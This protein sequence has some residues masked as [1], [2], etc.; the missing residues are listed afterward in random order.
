MQKKKKQQTQQNQ[1]TRQLLGI[2]GITEYSLK[3]ASNEAVFFSIKPS[4]ISVMSEASLSAKIYSLMSV[5][6]GLTEIDILCVNSRESF[7][8]NKNH[9]KT[10]SQKEENIAV[11]KLLEQDM[12]HLDQI[13]ALTATA[14]EFLLIVRIR[15]MKDKEIFAHLNR[16]E[17]TLNENGFSARRYDGE[18]IKTLLA[19]YFE[20]NSVTEKFESYDGERYLNG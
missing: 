2:E 15:R 8:G 7:E 9:L 4:N 18:D 1:S 13:Q 10:L 14:R 11:R 19:V 17:K 16:I 12:K 3:T 20:Q 6:K 5:L